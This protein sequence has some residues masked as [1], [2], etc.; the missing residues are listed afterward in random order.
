[1]PII[2]RQPFSEWVKHSLGMHSWLKYSNGNY[3]C[4]DCPRMSY[5]GP[6]NEGLDD[7]RIGVE[8][9]RERIEQTQVK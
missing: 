6:Y 7:Y 1:M 9:W 5:D 3:I 2:K 4:R 8:E